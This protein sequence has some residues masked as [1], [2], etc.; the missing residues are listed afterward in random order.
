M[1]TRSKK[2][3]LLEYVAAK[4]LEHKL[5]RQT[6]RNAVIDDITKHYQDQK[7]FD[8]YKRQFYI[9][10]AE[11]VVFEDHGKDLQRHGP[12]VHELVRKQTDL[13][14]ESLD[15][16]AVF[17]G[18]EVKPTKLSVFTDEVF[19]SWNSFEVYSY[20]TKT[21][22]FK[23]YAGPPDVLAV[24]LLEYLERLQGTVFVSAERVVKPGT[25]MV[26]LMLAILYN[27][28][29]AP[30]KST[31]NSL[32]RSVKSISN[33]TLD[34]IGMRYVEP[35]SGKVRA[36]DQDMYEEPIAVEKS[37]AEAY[38]DADIKRKRSYLQ[39]KADLEMKAVDVVVEKNT[40]AETEAEKAVKKAVKLEVDAM[41]MLVNGK[42]MKNLHERLTM[43]ALNA[44]EI[45]V[46]KALDWQL[47]YVKKPGEEKRSD[48]ITM[49]EGVDDAHWNLKWHDADNK[50]WFWERLCKINPQYAAADGEKV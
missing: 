30:W 7:T 4:K 32:I 20:M 31:F 24:M 14:K 13:I 41:V 17:M 15:Q 9:S 6:E 12:T 42:L 28:D 36:R 25:V 22:T 23:E 49:E 45:E 40:T 46:L 26:L 3:E 47:G 50:H 44:Q 18:K 5:A 10:T 37:Y 21:T 38:L 35:P 39:T 11:R 34:E 1:E 16:Y 2:R 29:E 43:V 27:D 33:M 19:S 48:G 8:R